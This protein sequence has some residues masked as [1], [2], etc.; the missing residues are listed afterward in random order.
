MTDVDQDRDGVPD[1]DPRHLDPAGDL[2]SE[3]EDGTLSTATV[4]DETERE[5]LREWLTRAESGEF[6]RFSTK[7]R[8]DFRAISEWFLYFNYS[9]NAV[10]RGGGRRS[11][12]TASSRSRCSRGC[13][14]V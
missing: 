9:T 1:T 8:S 2:A 4:T 6:G 3:F 7:V 14:M 5:D 12:S 13:K 10:V 11:V